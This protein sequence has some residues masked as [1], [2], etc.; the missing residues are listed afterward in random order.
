MAALAYTPPASRYLAPAEPGGRRGLRLAATLWFATWALIGRGAAARAGGVALR[1]HES[2]L[3]FEEGPGR[4]LVALLGLLALASGGRDGP[5]TEFLLLRAVT[6][7]RDLETG[8]DNLRVPRGILLACCRRQPNRPARC[9]T[10]CCT[11]CCSGSGRRLRVLRGAAGPERLHRAGLSQRG[12]RLYDGAEHRQLAFLFD[13]L[14]PPRHAD[15]H[16]RR[17]PLRD[18]L[19][20]GCL[21]VPD[22]NGDAPRGRHRRWREAVA[23]PDPRTRGRSWRFGHPARAEAPGSPLTSPCSG[24]AD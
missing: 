13:L 10:C 21:Q 12:S 23:L 17:D 2:P 14:T 16:A 15:P 8:L 9:S 3:Q 7:P 4:G 1:V 22:R 24:R 11:P 5:R 6:A 20:G 18:R 19:A